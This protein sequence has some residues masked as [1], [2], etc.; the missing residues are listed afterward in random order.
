MDTVLVLNASDPQIC[1]FLK[2]MTPGQRVK[3]KGLTEESFIRILK[4]IFYH[5]QGD[6]GYIMC[7]RNDEELTIDCRQI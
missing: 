7:T 3:I 5:P 2:Q 1:K 4:I 6:K